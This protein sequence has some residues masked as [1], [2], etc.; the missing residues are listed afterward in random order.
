MPYRPWRARGG[1][2]TLVSDLYP[3]SLVGEGTGHT[4]C[5]LGLLP[6][7]EAKATMG[8]VLALYYT[9]PNDET[10]GLGVVLFLLVVHVV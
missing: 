3:T 1:A 9:R 4:C 2:P 6:T 10:A 7:T 8:N 5:G